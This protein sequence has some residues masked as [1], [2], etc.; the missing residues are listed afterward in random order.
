MSARVYLAAEAEAQLGAIIAW[1]RAN[2]SAGLEA[3]LLAEMEQAIQLLGQTP[4]IGQP[5]RRSSRPGVR[6]FLLRRSRYWLYY[7]HH[8]SRG[9]VYV[10]AI[11]GTARGSTP[12]L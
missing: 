2:T 3:T 4:G 1:S 11:W 12:T 8:R 6:R 9:V 10:L 7:V 5:F